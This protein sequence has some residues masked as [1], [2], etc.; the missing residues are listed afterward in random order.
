VKT[1]AVS[2]SVDTTNDES[3]GVK[4]ECIKEG[5]KLR[6]RVVSSGYNKDWNVQ[7]PRALRQLGA[8]F[9]VDSSMFLFVCLFVCLVGCKCKF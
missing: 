9:M 7:F 6:I 4:V 1:T 5:S 2:T 3:K 8:K